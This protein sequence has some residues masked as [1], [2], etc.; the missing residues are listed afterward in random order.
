MTSLWRI[1]HSRLLCHP[2]E[3]QDITP[4]KTRP[5][6]HQKTKRGKG[7]SQKSL[8]RGERGMEQRHCCDRRRE[9]LLCSPINLFVRCGK[10]LVVQCP[11]I[12]PFF[13]KKVAAPLLI[14]F[15]KSRCIKFGFLNGG[16]GGRRGLTRVKALC[17]GGGGGH[18][19]WTTKQWGGET[20]SRAKY[21]KIP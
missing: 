1:S 8:W 4:D 14:A 17:E 11:V 10:S 15:P 16:E 2:T 19:R 18:R 9:I 12:L 5:P 20:N 13:V 7:H 3:N 21:V 6:L